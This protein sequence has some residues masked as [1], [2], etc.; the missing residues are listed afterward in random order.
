LLWLSWLCC[1][2]DRKHVLRANLLFVS[3]AAWFSRSAV[4]AV[5]SAKDPPWV[6]RKLYG[7]RWWPAKGPVGAPQQ[8]R[9]PLTVAHNDYFYPV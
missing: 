5:G 2:K 6:S 1:S 3:S 7:L 4:I 9:E 8:H